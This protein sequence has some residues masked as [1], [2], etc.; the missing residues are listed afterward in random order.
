ML[1]EQEKAEARKA[2]Y[3]RGGRSWGL[4]GYDGKPPAL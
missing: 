2:T 1:T 4:P 3:W